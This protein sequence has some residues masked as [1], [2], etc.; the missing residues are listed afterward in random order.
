MKKR[1]GT[2]VLGIGKGTKVA[3]NILVAKG[4]TLDS[5][6][7]EITSCTKCTQLCRSRLAPTEAKGNKNNPEIIVVGEAPGKQEDVQGIPFVGRSGQLLD[8]ML[9]GF[10]W[11]IDTC[12]FTN[13]V[14]CR[15]ENN[16]TPTDQEISNCRGYLDVE[17]EQLKPKG[18]ILLGK[19]AQVI[20][21]QKDKR[22]ITQVNGLPTLKLQHPA[23]LLRNPELFRGSPKWLAWQ[24]LIRFKVLL[25]H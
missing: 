18:L 13:I 15:P 22:S 5:I 17:I 3:Q 16:R 25:N 8:V 19:T 1:K 9:K 14:R 21:D 10:D 23:Y 4:R 7:Q 20:T 2:K 11:G 24:N 6:N 12:Y